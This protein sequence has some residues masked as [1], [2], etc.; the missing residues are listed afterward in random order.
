[1]NLEEKNK[2]TGGIENDD[3]QDNEFLKELELLGK[4][5]SANEEL[6]KTLTE[7]EKQR[8]F[9]RKKEKER[10]AKE[11][12]EKEEKAR[13]E[14][15]E[16]ELKRKQEEELAKQ[17]EAEEKAE[18]EKEKASKK[19]RLQRLASEDIKAFKEKYPDID[20]N[21]FKNDADLYKQIKTRWSPEGES[22]VEVYESHIDFV[23]RI[24]QKAKEDV[25][26]AYAKKG[27][28]SLRGSGSSS[29]GIGDIYSQDDVKRIAKKMPTM[30]Q[31]EYDAVIDKYLRSVAFYSKK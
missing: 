17:K 12:A 29:G 4:E 8:E 30:T 1:M 27:T 14:Q 6:N 7:E 11:L 20:I 22:L 3:T 5:D 21:S 28:P 16:L 24:S 13:K 23:S 26:S 2:T 10:K 19:E 9:N 15:E 25:A 31:K 18:L